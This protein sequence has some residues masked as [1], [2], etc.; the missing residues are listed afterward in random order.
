MKWTIQRYVLR[1]VAQTWLAV[2]GVLVA[3]LVSNQ[4]S[5]GPWP[6]C[7][8]PVRPA[9]GVRSGGPRCGHE[10]VGDRAGQ[11]AARVVLTLG[12][13]YH[14]SEMAA[15]QACGFPPAR[16]LPPLFIFAS[17]IAVGAG[18]AVFRSSA[19]SRPVGAVDTAIGHQG[20][21]IRS[22][23]CRPFPFI[24]RRRCGVLRGAGRSRR[25]P[26]RCVRTAGSRRPDRTGAGRDRDLFEGI[27]ERYALRHAVQ[28]PP[29]RGS[30]GAVGLS[31]H[32][33]Q[34]TWHSDRDAG[35]YGRAAGPRH[36]A[37]A[38]VVGNSCRL[39]HRT[40]AVARVQ[41]R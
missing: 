14:D 2:T 37:D 24:Q 17:V 34:R 19:A 29:L 23:G 38:R 9:C 31:S 32:P 33:I 12:R 15:L 35:R 20:G 22:A 10:S 4:L 30:A 3:I 5:Q 27:C 16:L 21:A 13:M 25:R 1:E 39:R 40:A 36:Q 6:G 26:A 41:P 11:P 7:G 8:Q 28:R 18:M